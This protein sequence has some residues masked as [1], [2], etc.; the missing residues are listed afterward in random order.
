MAPTQANHEVLDLAG[1]GIG[2]F[3][4]SL[5]ALASQIENLN[6]KF[7]ER[8][9]NFE[10]HSEI[11]FNDSYMQTSYLKDLVTGVAPTNPHSFLNY[12]VQNGLFYSFMNTGR[13]SV[14]RKEFELYCQWVASNLAPRLSFNS[15]IKQLHFEDGTFLVE[16]DSGVT[17]ARNI[18][19]GTGLVPK[20]PECARPFINGKVFHAK[21]A[22]L[23]QVDLT[24]KRVAIIGGGQTGV[25]IFRNALAARWGRASSLQIITSRANL[26]PLD[27]SPFT[28]EYFTPG[29]VDQFFKLDPS[30]KGPI[31]AY[32]KLASDGNTPEYLDGL[33]NDL[34]QMKSIQKDERTIEILPYRRMEGMSTGAQG[35][36]LKIQNRFY[37]K[38]EELEADI[39]ILATGFENAIPELLAP[40]KHLI[41]FDLNGRFNFNSDFS[42]KWKG[43]AANKIFALNFSRHGHGIAEPQT[44]LMA[45]RSATVINALT[46]QEHFKTTNSVANFINYGAP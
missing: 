16:T 3:N 25:E 22:A 34:Y 38:S 10:W 30:F 42:L 6:F 39:V 33:Y 15:D 37:Q 1:I 7:F 41:S 27:N 13:T 26:E 12:L 44:S 40:I 2:P 31:A 9:A 11:I 23:A 28:N 21:S 45:W 5:A 46:G 36:K 35:F 29:Y 19:L 4:L 24:G 14:T 32:Q 17:R 20:I 18:C 8:K 43:G